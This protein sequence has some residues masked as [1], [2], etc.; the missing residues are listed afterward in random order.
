MEN[1]RISSKIDFVST[2]INFIYHWRVSI[3]TRG[4]NFI[5]NYFKKNGTQ[6]ENF[7]NVCSETRGLVQAKSHKKFDIGGAREQKDVKNRAFKCQDV[8]FFTNLWLIGRNF[9]L[10]NI[11]LRE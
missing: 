7:K 5:E 3:V 10:K 4:Y 9:K 2:K 11:V 6:W 8:T 1:Y